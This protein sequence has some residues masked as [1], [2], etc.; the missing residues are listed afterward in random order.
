MLPLLWD[1]LDSAEIFFVNQMIVQLGPP[2]NEGEF[3]LTLG[4]LHPPVLMGGQDANRAKLEALPYVTVRVVS[5]V[6][7]PVSRVRE[8]RDVLTQ[9]LDTY[10]KATSVG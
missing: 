8:L 5:K 6:A 4:Q 9:M 3:I 7:M 2:G 10:E 1:G